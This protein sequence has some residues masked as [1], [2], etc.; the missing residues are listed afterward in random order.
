MSHKP[1]ADVELTTE[2][3]IRKLFP[4]P[5]VEGMKRQINDEPNTDTTGPGEAIRDRKSST[6]RE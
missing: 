1:K 3:A 5:V 2:Q 4:K 6:R